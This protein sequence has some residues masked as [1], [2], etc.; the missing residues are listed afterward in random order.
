MKAR[1]TGFTLIELLVVIAI[2]AILAAILF[3]VFA[4]ARERARAVSCLS[5]TRNIGLGLSM[6]V[7]DYDELMPTEFAK[8]DSPDKDIIPKG[9]AWII[10]YDIQIL[11][12]IKNDQ[13][14]GCP[15]D[16]GRSDFYDF[17]W[18]KSDYDKNKK[19]SYGYVGAVNT[20]ERKNSG[21]DQPDPNTGMSVWQSP[22]AIASFDEPANTLS[23]IEEWG[24]NNNQPDSGVFGS[25]WGAAFTNCDNWK[26]AGRHKPALNNSEK[27]D[28]FGC[29]GDF[30]DNTKKPMRGHFDA[31]N[32]VFADSHV[33]AL[34][35]SQI[36]ANDW[37][38]YKLTKT[39]L[40][41]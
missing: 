11:P 1:R 31:T 23:I 6:Y 26:L 32:A 35:Y 34:K 29:A 18:R 19:R 7:Q 20:I 3:P 33:K 27:G 2:I 36:R 38:V 4:Q 37:N 8:I 14:F 25:P 40:N 39:N 21:N 16:S 24:L 17:V 22:H 13:V 5:N 12:Y 28:A 30:D 15:S 41:L 9:G 10:P